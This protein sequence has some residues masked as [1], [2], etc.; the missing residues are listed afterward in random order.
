[1][2][3][4]YELSNENEDEESGEKTQDQTARVCI[5]T[6]IEK[7]KARISIFS[8]GLYSLF[9]RLQYIVQN[10]LFLNPNLIRIEILLKQKK[11]EKGDYG[12]F[13]TLDILRSI[14]ICDH[15]NDSDDEKYNAR[16][17]ILRRNPDLETQQSQG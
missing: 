1:M 5:K 7:E 8:N 16:M 17:E 14:A 13:N 4:F 10:A 11:F 3:Q 15:L 6:V 9:Y 2:K 12:D